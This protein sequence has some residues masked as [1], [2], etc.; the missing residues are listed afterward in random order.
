MA[1]L[2]AVHSVCGSA[3]LRWT[4]QRRGSPCTHVNALCAHSHFNKISQDQFVADL[5]CDVTCNIRSGFVFI[6]YALASLQ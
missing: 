6:Y 3:V 2:V 4:Q 1:G 5:Q